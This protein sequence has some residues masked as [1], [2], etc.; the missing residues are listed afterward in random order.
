VQIYALALP[1][2]LYG[3][4]NWT[5][6]ARDARIITAAAM[7]YMRKTAGYSWS[8]YKTN[9]EIAKELNTT[10]VVE[11]VQEYRINLLQHINRMLSS[12][13]PR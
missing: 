4:E 13:L 12:R 2:L 5:T 6:K 1:A 7:K 3:S 8:D 11:K 9:T 10:P